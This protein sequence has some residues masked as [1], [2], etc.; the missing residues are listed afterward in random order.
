VRVVIGGTA[1][2]TANNLIAAIN[3]SSLAVT[4]APPDGGPVRV[5]LT[6]DTAFGTIGSVTHSDGS[7]TVRPNFSP[8]PEAGDRL[9]IDLGGGNQE[10]FTFVTG[11]PGPGEVQIG[12]DIDTTRD[13]LIA[14][15][16]DSS[17]NTLIIA[18]DA[19]AGVG[20]RIAVTHRTN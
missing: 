11:V 9:S 4:A 8:Q 2:A 20:R 17:L 19:S 3:E 13:N 10:A 16:N 15:I 5:L 7:V 14:A 18:N 6:H 1:A 12:G